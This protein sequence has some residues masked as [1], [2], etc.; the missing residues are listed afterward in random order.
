ML[1]DRIIV[2]G[3]EIAIHI[4]SIEE[5]K[6]MGIAQLGGETI[7]RRSILTDGIDGAPEKLTCILMIH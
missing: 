3:P 4:R 7:E 1:H 5:G 6:A 2:S